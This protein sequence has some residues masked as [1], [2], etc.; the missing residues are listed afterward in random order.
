LKTIL[1]CIHH[2]HSEAYATCMVAGNDK[3]AETG[4]PGHASPETNKVLRNK[5][6]VALNCT[7]IS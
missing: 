4:L 1:I 2:R 7:I 6:M 5:I 3:K